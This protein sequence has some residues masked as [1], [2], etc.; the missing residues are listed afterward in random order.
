MQ[1][2]S[3]RVAVTDMRSR[4]YCRKST[5]TKTLLM[6]LRYVFSTKAVMDECALFTITVVVF[7]LVV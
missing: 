5:A 4:I 3:V 6:N 7:L 2:Q 1:V